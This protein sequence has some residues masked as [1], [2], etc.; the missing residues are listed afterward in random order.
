MSGSETGL[1]PLSVYL[2]VFLTSRD[3][4]CATSNTLR[5]CHSRITRFTR[6]LE[7]RS[8]ESIEAITPNYIRQFIV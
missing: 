1:H 8:V 6:Y 7:S 2:E 4:Q 5:W 3:A